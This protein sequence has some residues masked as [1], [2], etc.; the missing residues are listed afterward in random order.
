M[1]N[2][3]SGVSGVI[4]FR[5]WSRRSWAVFSSLGRSIRIGV[6]CLSC[7]I[8][9]LP[10]YSQEQPDSIPSSSSDREIELE[11][12]VVSA[13]RSP[14][15]QS[16]LMRVVQVV[17]R[18]EIA[19]HSSAGLAGLLENLRGVDIR[20]RGAFG[21]QADIS[22]RGGTFDQ[23]LILLNGINL[24]D[25]QTG[26]HNLNL[27]VDLSSVER[28]EVLQ[29]PG[30]RIFGPNAFNGAINIITA[31][32]ATHGITATISGGEFGLFQSSVSAVAA[33]GKVNQHISLGWNRSDGYQENT[34]FSNLNMY[35]R[36]VV[37]SGAG[38]F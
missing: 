27:P 33:L 11:E 30:A 1:E 8:L 25:P 6:L 12:V 37:P 34:D 9:V 15:V 10:G 26:H 7:S 19:Q 31:A 24:T 21:M 23:T 13:Q 28:I 3:Q 20:Q 16:Q 18:A 4:S 14:V 2:L 36:A 22:I 17:T 35:Y 5:R 32:P 38:F 29:G